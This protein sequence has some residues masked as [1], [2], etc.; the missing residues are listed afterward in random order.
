[1]GTVPEGRGW[2]QEVRKSGPPLSWSLYVNIIPKFELH[3]EGSARHVCVV[4]M[5]D[6]S[7]K[8]KKTKKIST[9]VVQF[10]QGCDILI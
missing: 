3:I 7:S 8:N 4:K 10:S 6:M 9:H 1:M 5:S 2:C